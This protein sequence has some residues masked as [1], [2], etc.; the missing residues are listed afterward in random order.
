MNDNPR[1]AIYGAYH[2]I[3]PLFKK[4]GKRKKSRV[5]GPICEN[6][7]EFGFY[8]LPELKLGDLLLIY[9]CGAYVRTMASNYNGRL[10]PAEFICDKNGLKLIRDSQ[11]FENLIENERY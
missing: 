7:D 2:H 9:N 8:E 5:V 6:A 4:K 11:N 3:E 1:P 10:L